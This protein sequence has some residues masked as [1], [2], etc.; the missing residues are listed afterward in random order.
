MYVKIQHMY[1]EPMRILATILDSTDI[2]H[3]QHRQ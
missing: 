2:E 1:L 3:F